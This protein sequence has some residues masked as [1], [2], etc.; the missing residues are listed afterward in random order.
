MTLLHLGPLVT[1][2][3]L[4]WNSIAGLQKSVELGELL[5]NLKQ[6]MNLPLVLVAP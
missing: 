6:E 4:L 1:L 5:F 3:L 2:Y